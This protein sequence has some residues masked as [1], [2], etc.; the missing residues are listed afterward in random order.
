MALSSHFLSTHPA[1]HPDRRS[2]SWSNAPAINRFTHLSYTGKI[3]MLDTK[4]LRDYPG[5][6]TQSKL[7]YKTQMLKKIGYLL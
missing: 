1:D 7:A 3:H 6:V 5:I 4:R 2:P